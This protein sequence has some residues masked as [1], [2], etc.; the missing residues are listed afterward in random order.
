MHRRPVL[1]WWIRAIFEKAVVLNACRPSWKQIK[2]PISCLNSFNLCCGRQTFLDKPFQDFQERELSISNRAQPDW[3]YEFPDR[4][5]PDTQIC[6][7]RPALDIHFKNFTYQI[8]EFHWSSSNWNFSF[9]KVNKQKRIWNKRN[10]KSLKKKKYLF[11][12]LVSKSFKS[13]ASGKENFPF[14]DSPDFD[15]FLDFQTRHDVR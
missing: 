8:T 6:R 5:G 4:T 1:W 2:V 11:F 9:K 14:P 13:L 12:F 15:S 7:T 3:A 10:F